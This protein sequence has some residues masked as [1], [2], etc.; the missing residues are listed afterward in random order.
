MWVNSLAWDCLLVTTRGSRVDG[1]H[2]LR[3]GSGDGPG[4]FFAGSSRVPTHSR[5]IPFT[6]ARIDAET[7]RLH[8]SQ[9]FF[10]PTECSEAIFLRT[11]LCILHNNG[12]NLVRLPAYDISAYFR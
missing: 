11:S 9:D 5:T 2:F 12:F 3:L 6:S 10:L 7:N 8:A 1:Y 4:W